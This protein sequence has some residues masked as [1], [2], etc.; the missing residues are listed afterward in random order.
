M[1]IIIIINF[2]TDLKF[3]EMFKIFVKKQ[4]P[5]KPSMALMGIIMYNTRIIF[6]FLLFLE[7]RPCAAANWDQPPNKAHTKPL[8]VLPGF[9]RVIVQFPRVMYFQY[10]Y[11]KHKLTTSLFSQRN[12]KTKHISC[13][14][15]FCFW[16]CPAVLG[17]YF[18]ECLGA[19]VGC[20]DWTHTLPTFCS[21]SSPYPLLF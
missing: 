21:H 20:W 10:V 14:V 6:S 9:R 12:L 13:F 16:P 15:L 19:H 11:W 17:L 5:R 3:K 1:K 7:P 18:W 2:E 8:Y 4:F